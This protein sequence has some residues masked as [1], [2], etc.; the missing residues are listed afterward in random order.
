MTLTKY[1]KYPK[2]ITISMAYERYFSDRFKTYASFFSFAFRKGK[3]HFRRIKIDNRFYVNENHII[4][5]LR[6][7][8]VNEIRKN[9]YLELLY[10]IELEGKLYSAGKLLG[11]KHPVQIYD[12]NSF[13]KMG[14]KT[15]RLF[16]KN[17]KVLLG[18]LNQKE[19]L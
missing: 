5:Y 2:N 16:R 9:R 3:E 4:K 10:D 15:I 8:E 13:G 17:Y 6:K 18:L 14:P 19:A 12:I 7:R 1:K 11:F